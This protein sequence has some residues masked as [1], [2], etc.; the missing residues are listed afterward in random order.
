MRE[1][2]RNGQTI[3]KNEVRSVVYKYWINVRFESIMEGKLHGGRYQV[4]M[5]CVMIMRLQEVHPLV[6]YP[7]SYT[8]CARTRIA[9][10]PP[11]M[12]VQVTIELQIIKCDVYYL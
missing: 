7:Y 1:D 10:R 4:T 9:D 2:L 3:G 6:P 12:P 8:V 11:K 5:N